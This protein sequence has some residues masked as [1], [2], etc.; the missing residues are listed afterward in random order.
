MNRRFKLVI[1]M[2][3]LIP[4]F[5]GFYNGYVEVSKP[6][7]PQAKVAYVRQQMPEFI[8]RGSDARIVTPVL[9]VERP[10]I[11]YSTWEHNTYLYLAL[12]ANSPLVYPVVSWSYMQGRLTGLAVN[13]MN[14][15]SGS[16][17]LQI[18]K[19]G[20]TGTM[21]LTAYLYGILATLELYYDFFRYLY[22]KIRR[23]IILAETPWPY[24]ERYI[25]KLTNGLLLIAAAAIVQDYVVPLIS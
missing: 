1:V 16:V 20:I 25:I 14:A 22:M 7:A 8:N 13:A 21:E 5:L 6:I 9:S 2:I 3:Y 18:V 23:D 17:V 4:F 11:T 12:C 19:L 24:F 10:K 15:V